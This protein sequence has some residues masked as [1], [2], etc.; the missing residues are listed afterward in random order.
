[1]AAETGQGMAG[2]MHC[3]FRMAVSC[4]QGSSHGQTCLHLLVKSDKD[5]TVLWKKAIVYDAFMLDRVDRLWPPII[6]RR[7]IGQETG[8]SGSE[9]SFYA[10]AAYK[11]SAEN[12]SMPI[13]LLGT[14]QA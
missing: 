2:G 8:T 14:Q 9:G 10:L 4:L 12:S 3:L 1:M 11:A 5:G 6:A 7:V 13:K